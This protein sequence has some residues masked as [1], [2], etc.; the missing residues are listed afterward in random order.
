MDKFGKK[1]ILV[2]IVTF[3]AMRWIDNCLGSIPK[4]TI[5]LSSIIIDNNSQDGTVDYIKHN[6][7][8]VKIIQNKKNLGFGKGNNLGLKFAVEQKYDYAFLLN[9]DAWIYPNTVKKMLDINFADKQLGIISPVQLNGKGNEL[10]KNFST[11]IPFKTIAEVKNANKD[12]KAPFLQ[13]SFVNAAAWL[14]SRDCFLKTGGFDHIFEHYGEDRDY[15]YRASYHCFKIGIALNTTICHD[16]EYCKSNQH[17]KQENFLF[18]V[19]L[20][21]IKNVNNTLIYNYL[22]WIIQRLK[23]SIKLLLLFDLKSFYSEIIVLGKLL[24]M[25]KKIKENRK[26][27]MSRKKAF[28]T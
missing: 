18:T 24:L 9:Q 26:I 11:Y 27:S 12:K 16:R 20:A 4:S 1:R 23:K 7:P 15:C 5:P 28:L 3:N 17:R 22:T 10:D 19:G 14:I 2:I 21:H 13:T 8:E 6:F 25:T